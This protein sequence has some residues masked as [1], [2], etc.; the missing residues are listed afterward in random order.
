VP[1]DEELAAK[2]EVD[3]AAAAAANTPAARFFK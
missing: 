2:R 3:A 1:T